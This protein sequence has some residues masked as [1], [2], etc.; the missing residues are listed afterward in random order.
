MDQ[1]MSV[2]SVSS[3]TILDNPKWQT[4]S[5]L[6]NAG[7]QFKLLWLFTIFWNAFTWVAIILGGDNILKAFEENPVFYFFV[8]FPF[9]G[10][11]MIHQAVKETLAWKKFGKTPL[12]MTPFPG[13]LGGVV[14]GYVDVPVPYD[15]AHEV[16]ISLSCMHYYWTKRG[17]ETESTSE[18][19]WQDDISI[20]SKPSSLGSRLHFEFKPPADLPETEPDSKDHHGWEVQISLPLE[21]S[22]YERQFTIPV[23]RVSEQT[24]ASSARYAR[25]S[26]DVISQNT[27]TSDD[28]IPQISFASGGIHFHYPQF[29]N[30]GMGIGLMM[31]GVFISVFLWFM[32]EG[33][34]D[35]LPV[36][37]M[38]FFGFTELIA[39]AI[40]AFGLF[41]MSN[42][43]TVDAGVSGVNVSHKIFG[44]DFGGEIER[45]TI[46][47]IVTEKS[48][49]SSNGK[50]STVW[51]SLKLIQ[52]DGKDSTVGD[53]LEGYSYA[54]EIRLQM[55]AALG[56]GWSPSEV[57]EKM[58]ND[59]GHELPLKA[60][61][62]IKILR[63]VVGLAIPVAI[64]YD[65]RRFYPGI[66]ET[67]ETLLQV[68]G[69]FQ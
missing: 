1:R 3:T 14:G 13:Q 65:C 44:F 59:Q 28:V 19:I 24:I 27:T 7:S 4:N 45:S 57:L 50:F 61:V 16:K 54:Q 43:M 40:F 41:L 20:R 21:G 51:Y 33:F 11:F 53:S 52:K 36:T 66:A 69:L 12:T 67:V 23:I 6:S 5:I 38:V 15:S 26:I 10:F 62:P 34:V 29:R 39:V 68:V 58:E 56:T 22:D 18:A 25:S 30:K 49:S 64:I 60:R 8:L 31:A 46:A 17:S 47:D 35:F 37:S 48:G 55:I 63:N 42:S 32:Q 2:Q 9:I